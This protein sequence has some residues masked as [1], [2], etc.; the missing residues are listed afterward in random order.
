MALTLKDIITVDLLKKTMLV[1]VDLT[2]DAGNAYPDELFEEAIDQAISLMEEELEITIEP[3][4][5]SSE[6][7]DLYNDQRNAWYGSQLDRRPLKTIDG[8]KISYGNYSPVDIPDAWLNIT[9]PETSS[10]SLIP[11]AESI[12]TF[13]FNNVLPLLIDPI[14]NYGRYARV[15]AYFNFDYTAGFTLLEG[16][17][18]IPQGTTE[19]TDIAIGETLIDKPRFIFEVIDDGN[20]N[21]QGASSPSVKAFGIGDKTF[22]VEISAAGLQGDV[23]IDYKL[24]TVPPVLVKAILYTA[25]ML[26]LDTAGDLLAGAGVGQFTLG[27][28]GLSQSISTTS[29]ATSAGYGAKI[30]SYK[31]QL[32]NAMAVL[33]KKY[34]VSKLAAGF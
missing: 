3:F 23:V 6:R 22:N 18:T 1:G 26:P 9:S 21:I 14:S 34:K 28:D 12:G 29:S 20:G 31:D 5:V 32:K 17:I 27:V 4:K 33:K 8:L 16:Q 25:A 2:D 24:H 13:R 10:V 15:P 19:L 7:H 11:T 30:I